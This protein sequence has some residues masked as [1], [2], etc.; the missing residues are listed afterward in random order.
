MILSG[1]E[2]R[3]EI[4][5]GRIQIEPFSDDQIGPASVDLH[6]DNEFRTFKKAHD[7]FHVHD[8]TDYKKITDLVRV[9]NY[10]LLMPGE[11]VHGITKEKLTLPDDICGWLE[12]RSR[13]ARIGLLV[14]ITAS[15]MQPGI[16]NRQ[17]LEMNNVAPVPLAIYPGTRL[18]QFIFQ[19]MEGKARYK[20]IYR[21]QDTL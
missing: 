9:D 21:K 16:S 15:F 12:G 8:E 5:K 1:D 6:L 18:C 19:R 14:H 17:V 13:F 2:I 10:F 4:K 20:G 7:I 3:E 11:T